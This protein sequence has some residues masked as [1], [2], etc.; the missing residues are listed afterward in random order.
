MSIRK[1][2]IPVAGYG[3]R[4]LPFTKSTPKEMLPIVDKPVIQY[5]V[6]EA[7]SAGIEEIILITGYTKRAIEDYFDYTAELDNHLERHGKVKDREMI[8]AISD[9]ARFTYI[10]QKEM[11]GNGHALLQAK[12]AIG[13]DPFLVL[14]ADEVYRGKPGLVQ[15]LIEAYNEVQSPVIHVRECT[16][17]GDGDKFGYIDI[18]ETVSDT[19]FK[20]NTLV[21]KPGENRSSNYASLGGYVLTPEIFPILEQQAPGHGGEVVTADAIN[22][23]AQRRPV[24]A[25][26]CTGLEYYDCGSKLG[27]LE[28]TVRIALDR[29]D[30]GA[31]FSKILKSIVSSH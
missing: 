8:R 24:Y 2:V 9:M 23:L 11:K 15:Q 10:R 6:E 20:I 26:L 4:F 25:K 18:A 14:W 27:Y 5:V 12:S 30:I 16:A 22:T 3:T 28:A 17:P 1:A 13:N 31:E 19:L 29:P 21:E 7:V